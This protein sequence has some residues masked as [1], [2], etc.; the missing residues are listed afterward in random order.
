MF[1]F[2]KQ[3]FNILLSFS[4]SLATTCVSFN[5]EQCMFRPTLVDLNPVDLK[6]Y[7][8]MISLDKY[9]GSCNVLSPKICVPKETKNINVRAFNMITDKN[10]AKTMTKRVSSDCKCKFNSTV[11]NSNQKMNNKTCQYSVKIIVSAKRL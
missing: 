10:E 2:I 8:F 5:D 3:V 1:S 4:S 9:T 6:H 11:C 7:S